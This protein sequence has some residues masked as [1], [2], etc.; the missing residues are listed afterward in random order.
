MPTAKV[1]IFLI[2]ECTNR[3][4]WKWEYGETYARSVKNFKGFMLR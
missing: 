4:S 2:A 1:S 3:G